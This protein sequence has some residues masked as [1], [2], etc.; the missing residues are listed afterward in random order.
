MQNGLIHNYLV[1]IDS[2]GRTLNRT[3]VSTSGSSDPTDYVATGLRPNT[4]YHVYV[5]AVNSQGA[6]PPSS[7]SLSGKTS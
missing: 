3:V 5:Q 2:S 6:G 1:T 4:M 7:P